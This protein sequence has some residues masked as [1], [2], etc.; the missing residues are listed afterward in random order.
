MT[1]KITV[2]LLESQRSTIQ[3]V[4]LDDVRLGLR[5]RFVANDQSWYIW[6]TDPAGAT[7]AGPIRLVPG[8][9]FLR[10]FQYD[11]RCPPGQ[12]FIHGDTPNAVTVDVDSVL[13]YRPEAD[14]T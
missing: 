1:V 12:M 13:L 2:R 7:F 4:T 10:S 8:I 6:L 9:N 3:F 5:S 14:V 11:P